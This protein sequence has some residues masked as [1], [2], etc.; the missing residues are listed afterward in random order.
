MPFGQGRLTR[1]D[2]LR[3]TG[4]LALGGGLASGRWSCAAPAVESAAEPLLVG[5][6]GLFRP[7]ARGC[8]VQWIPNGPIEARL[9]A[10]ADPERLEE[11]AEARGATG[12]V[13]TWDGAARGGSAH[14]R[15]EARRRTG[16]P[17]SPWSLGPVRAGRAPGT[18]FRVAILA[19][20]H[21]YRRERGMETNL[22]AT[23]AAV[24]RDRPD[25]VVYLGDEAGVH[26]TQHPA[27]SAAEAA[28]RWVFW[29]QRFAPLVGSVPGFLVLGN[30]V[31]E[32][33][34]YG[35]GAGQ[36]DSGSLQGWATAARRA[37]FAN[38][39]PEAYPEGGSPLENYF[40]WTWGDAL[41]VVL[42]VHR[43]TNPGGAPPASVEEWTLGAAQLAWLERTLASSTARWKLVFAHHLVGGSEWDLSASTRRTVY[44]YGRGG[45]RY[46]LVGEQARVTAALRDAGGGAFLY[47]HDHVFAD[48]P[49]EGV[50]FLCCGR[51]TIH[52]EAD[53]LWWRGPGWAEAYG[54]VAA[55]DPYDFWAAIG[56]VRLE[57]TP[58]RATLQLVRTAESPGDN[59]TT[60]LGEVFHEA[61]LA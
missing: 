32:A 46:A 6:P 12:G 40:A 49:A 13:M 39:G 23:L 53:R 56:Y 43:Y 31:G 26:T 7:T 1:R 35:R 11:V 17:W 3:G 47:G 25:F 10:G 41:F 58:Q 48:Q 60:P 28:A 54:D 36:G 52:T 8:A 24:A 42:D 29:R 5:A 20:S 44:K 45:G 14:L 57:V 18:S 27:G 51:T 55:R 15:F 59:V 16:E 30:H 9:L 34:Y 38:P 22:E 33:G 50:R 4:A 21:I 61:S 37:C 2:L 19:D